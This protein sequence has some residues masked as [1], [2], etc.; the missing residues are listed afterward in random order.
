MAESFRGK[1][2]LRFAF[3]VHNI[4]K[5]SHSIPGAPDKH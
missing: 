5:N 2:N 1:Q 3:S 4:V